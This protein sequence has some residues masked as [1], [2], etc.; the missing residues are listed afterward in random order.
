M[1]RTSASASQSSNS[2]IRSFTFIVCSAAGWFVGAPRS[3]GTYRLPS[4]GFPR[5]RTDNR[6]RPRNCAFPREKSGELREIEP[7]TQHAGADTKRSCAHC[8]ARFAGPACGLVHGAVP[9]PVVEA[10]DAATLLVEPLE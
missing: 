3:R 9:E 10:G 1:M 4:E 2:S 5:R 7:A 8:E 6:P